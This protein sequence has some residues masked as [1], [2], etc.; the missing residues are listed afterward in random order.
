MYWAIYG[1]VFFATLAMMVREGLWS[2][3][4]T[5]INIIISGIVAFGFFSPLAV[6][7]D[8]MT[9]GQYTY[10]MDFLVIWALYVVTMLVCQSITRAASKTRMRFKHPI[11]PVGGPA[12]ALI[13]AWVMGSFVMATLHASPMPKDAFGGKLALSDSDVDTASSIGSPDLAWL[14]FMEQ[15]SAPDA[16]GS[17]GTGKFTA[18]GYVKIYGL[19]R[20]QLDAAKLPWIRARR[21]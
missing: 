16:L 6:Y 4:I 18:R 19:H 14:R 13:A 1:A 9:D 21:G 12:V 2:N 11:D 15:M 3:T 7:F 17:G 20:E 10:L 8:E 5:L